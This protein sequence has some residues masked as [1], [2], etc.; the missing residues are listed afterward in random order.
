MK[1]AC[2]IHL[3]SLCPRMSFSQISGLFWLCRCLGPYWDRDLI[4]ICEQRMIGLMKQEIALQE[5][6]EKDYDA[7]VPEGLQTLSINDVD[8]IELLYKND[9]NF[10]QY[11]PRQN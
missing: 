5:K 7:D 1:L 8:F 2:E 11:T 9:A 4:D 3:K 10:L 6:L